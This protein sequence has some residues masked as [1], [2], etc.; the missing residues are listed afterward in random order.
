M[1]EAAARRNSTS[2]SP[3][4]VLENDVVVETS[5][6]AQSTFMDSISAV[7]SPALLRERESEKTAVQILEDILAES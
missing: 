4:Y 2:T 3:L 1:K 6:S 5:G 7:A